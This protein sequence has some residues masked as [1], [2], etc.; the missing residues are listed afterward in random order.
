[1]SKK[2]LYESRRPKRPRAPI[3]TTDAPL[4][5]PSD[6]GPEETPEFIERDRRHAL[7][8]QH[9]YYL[10]EERGFEP[11][12]ELDDW[13]TAERDV[14]QALASYSEGSRLCGD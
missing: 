1:M 12:R 13:L 11:G 2:L 9:A 14:E 3:Q 8:A 10:A 5:A 7:I 6:Q 4:E